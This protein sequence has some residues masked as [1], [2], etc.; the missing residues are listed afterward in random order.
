MP[1]ND[2]YQ[3]TS[4]VSD[5]SLAPQPHQF[6]AA[7]NPEWSAP[8]PPEPV[9]EPEP[10]L[11]TSDTSLPVPVVK[12]LSVHGVEY[13]MMTIALWV[14]A[15]AMAW[16]LLNLINSGTSFD[17]LI[18]PVSAL[19]TSLP[20][21]GLLFI[22]LRSAELSNPSLRIDPSKRRWSQTT[23]L[24]AFVTCLVNLSVFAYIALQKVSGNSDTSIGKTI[25]DLLV[26]LVIAGGILA[27]YWFDEHRGLK[28]KN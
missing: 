13:A 7:P 9:K 15:A 27:Y 4:S 1:P 11:S 22:R 2:P 17:L 3:P 21:F 18:V 25:A 5:P 26:I 6:Q 28:G 14:T 8:L 16:A 20:I 24:L 23:Q 19:I 12:V 10:R